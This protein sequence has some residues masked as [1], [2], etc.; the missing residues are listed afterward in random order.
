MEKM[1]YEEPTLAIVAFESDDVI[2]T[3]GNRGWKESFD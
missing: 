3:S 2:T 1:V